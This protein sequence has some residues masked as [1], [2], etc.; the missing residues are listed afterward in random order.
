MVSAPDSGSSGP[1][2]IPGRF[3]VL[4]S[5]ARHFTLTVPLSTQR[6][7]SK[8][9]GKPDEMLGVTCDGLASHPPPGG[10]AILLVASCYGNRDKL[11]LCGPLGSCADCFFKLTGFCLLFSYRSPFLASLKDRLLSIYGLPCLM[12]AM[13]CRHWI[14]PLVFLPPRV[15]SRRDL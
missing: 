14:L 5:W 7:T 4:C 13:L 15:A 3:I 2:S 9:S 10:V 8:L 12:S 1:G 11:R 6:G